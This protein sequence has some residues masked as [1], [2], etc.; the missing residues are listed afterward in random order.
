[1]FGIVFDNHTITT[2]TTQCV[3]FMEGKFLQWEMAS[4]VGEF[5][6]SL[7][8]PKDRIGRYK[9]SNAMLPW[10]PSIFSCTSFVYI[11]AI[12]F[13]SWGH[14]ALVFVVVRTIERRDK[15]VSFL[16]IEELVSRQKYCCFYQS[17]ISI[18][19]WWKHM[20]TNYHKIF[21]VIK[22]T[23]SY[24]MRYFDCSYVLFVW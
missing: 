4:S 24:D 12:G 16:R 19:Y 22:R 15:I 21:F 13:L 18:F 20:L 8:F 3:L 10:K 5:S 11:Y 7:N 6:F 1:M 14:H 9:K 23:I 2:T 17:K